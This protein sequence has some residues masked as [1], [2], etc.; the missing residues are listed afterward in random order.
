MKVVYDILVIVHL[1][2]MA[3]LVGGWFAVAASPRVSALMT[4]GA[5]AQ[6]LSGVVLV[7]LG[8]SASALDKVLDH[9]KV[10]LKLL[11]AVAVLACAEMGRGR[12]QRGG[13]AVGLANAAG[14]LAVLNVIV[15]VGW[16]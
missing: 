9:N 3:A 6:L 14:Y 13:R 5:R 15:A 2:G 1:L 11:I 4:W 16:P 12:Q 8:E 10:G 7:G